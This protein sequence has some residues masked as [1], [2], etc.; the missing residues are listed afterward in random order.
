MPAVTRLLLPLIPAS[1][2]ESMGLQAHLEEKQKFEEK[3]MRFECGD[4]G[5]RERA[6][7]AAFL[8]M[9]QR[10]EKVAGLPYPLQAFIVASDEVNAFALPGGRVYINAG[11]FKY[12]KSA[13]EFAGIVG[14]EIGH[15]AHRDSVRGALHSAGLSFLFGMVLGDVIGI[16]GVSLAAVR[17]LD[18]K[19]TRAQETAADAFGAELMNK[20]GA[21]SHAVARVFERMSSGDQSPMLFSDHPTD[22]SR[23]KAIRAMPAVASPKPIL[24]DKEWQTLLG[25]CSGR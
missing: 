11:M 16:R 8:Q 20:V 3:N 2:E 14:H 10:L 12:S 1:A 19:H 24:T 18:Q 4:A 13:D 17:L 21:D 7:K 23:I 15:V 25:V 9:V 22:A 5:K 6:G